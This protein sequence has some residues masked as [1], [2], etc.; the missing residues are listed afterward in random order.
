MVSRARGP[1]GRQNK[2]TQRTRLS[3]RALPRAQAIQALT[4]SRRRFCPQVYAAGSKRQT[5][6]PPAKALPVAGAIAFDVEGVRRSAAD[7]CWRWSGEEQFH[8]GH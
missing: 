3:G 8:L 2:K 1:P 7:S 4:G 5:V 6:R